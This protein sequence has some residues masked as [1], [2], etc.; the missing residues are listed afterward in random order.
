[1]LA[2]PGVVA[3]MAQEAEAIVGV[4]N[5]FVTTTLKRM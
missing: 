3:T 1:M 5:Q 4:I 2:E